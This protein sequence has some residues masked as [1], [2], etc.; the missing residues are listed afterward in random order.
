MHEKPARQSR[1]PEVA[2]PRTQIRHPD[3]FP[4]GAA[5]AT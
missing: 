3:A 1:H 5:P 2:N 4:D